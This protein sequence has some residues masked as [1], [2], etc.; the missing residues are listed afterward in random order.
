MTDPYNTNTKKKAVLDMLKRSRGIVSSACEGADI[1]RVTFYEWVKT[2]P[3]FK[4]QVDEINES[5]IDFVESKLFQK[6]N[7]IEC[8]TITQKGET[9]VYE[10]PPSDTAIIFYLKTKG[11][12][13]GYV[14]RQE[15]TGADGKGILWNETKSYDTDQKAD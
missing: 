3:E 7:G 5:A 11:K 8:A 4:E 12:P 14:E 6:I 1:S 15:V 13:R 10:V 9:V 2:D